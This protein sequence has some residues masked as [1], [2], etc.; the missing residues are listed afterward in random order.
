VTPEVLCPN[1]EKGEEG[2]AQRREDYKLNAFSPSYERKDWKKNKSQENPRK[3]RKVRK[4]ATEQPKKEERI[5]LFPAGGRNG[6]SQG[7]SK[8]TVS[9]KGKC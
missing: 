1:G 8:K 5:P 2:A 9:T 4:G 7:F 3:R 6:Y